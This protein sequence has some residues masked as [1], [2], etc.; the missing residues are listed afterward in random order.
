MGMA[1][2]TWWHRHPAFAAIADDPVFKEFLP[3]N[4]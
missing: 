1:Y 3:P 4:G 2:Q